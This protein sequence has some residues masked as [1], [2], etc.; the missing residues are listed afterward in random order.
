MTLAQSLDAGM[1]DRDAGAFLD[2]LAERPEVS[3][4]RVGTTG[5]CMGGRMS[6]LAAATWTVAVMRSASR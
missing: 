3:G 1:A 5:Y 6:L 4:T 2:F